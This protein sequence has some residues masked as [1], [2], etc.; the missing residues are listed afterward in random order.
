[1]I[2][3]VYYL[4]LKDLLDPHKLYCV[5]NKF[6]VAEKCLKIYQKDK[7]S[8]EWIFSFQ[9]DIPQYG[10]KLVRSLGANYNLFEQ[11]YQ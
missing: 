8:I 3:L 9:R 2:R 7:E 11:H 1:M 4:E 10:K 6:E 5:S